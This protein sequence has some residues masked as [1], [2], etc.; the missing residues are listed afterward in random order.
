MPRSSA[1]E[2]REQAA[3]EGRDAPQLA[4]MRGREPILR[5]NDD[6]VV[7]LVARRD[8][9]RVRADVLRHERERDVLLRPRL[10]PRRSTS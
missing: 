7:G 9:L 6:K 10:Q 3:E 4:L 1:G 8:L 2:L 5:R